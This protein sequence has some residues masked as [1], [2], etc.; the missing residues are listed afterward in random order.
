ME[1]PLPL[2]LAGGLISLISAATGIWL[3]HFLN[4]RKMVH[5]AKLHPSRVLYDKQIEF[6]DSFSPLFDEINGYV[7][8]IDV[9]LAER[10]ETATVKVE[11][12]MRNTSCLAE[13]DKLLHQYYLYIPSE[14][15]DK[16][17]TLSST[18]WILSNAP[19]LDKTY[20]SI[21]LLF[22]TENAVREFVGV[23]KLSQDL[24]KAMGR[25]T[26]R[27]QKKVE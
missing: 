8:S 27:K 23:D 17:N 10:T 22:E 14:L 26:P 6:L 25:K 11:E 13:M 5:E 24:M 12:A 16:I 4:M 19:D 1:S 21:N 9:W 20:Q 2:L 15:L 3:Q 18:C 7:T